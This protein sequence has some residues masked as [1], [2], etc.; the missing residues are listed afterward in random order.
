M[1][2]NKVYKVIVL[3]LLISVGVLFFYSN[4]RINKL[5]KENIE[6]KEAKKIELRKVRDSA[7]VKIDSIVSSSSKKFDSILNIPPTIKWRKYEKPIYINRSLDDA[8]DVISGYKYNKRAEAK[9]K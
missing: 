8:L 7:F 3:L 6:L 5:K 9:D 4:N 1:I 2:S